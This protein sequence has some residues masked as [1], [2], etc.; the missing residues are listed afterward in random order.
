[1]LQKVAAMFIHRAILRGFVTL[2]RNNKDI[3]ATQTQLSVRYRA[4]CF[5]KAKALANG[6]RLC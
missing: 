5:L 4:G 2:H 3:L 1:L 6:E